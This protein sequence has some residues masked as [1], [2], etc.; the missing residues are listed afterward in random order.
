MG[1]ILTEALAEFFLIFAAVLL[2]LHIGRFG[3]LGRME[4]DVYFSLFFI[5]S[6]ILLGIILKMFSKLND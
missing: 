4:T 1:S 5:I 3:D 6:I 2:G